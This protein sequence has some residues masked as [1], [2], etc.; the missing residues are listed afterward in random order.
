MMR[1]SLR[2]RKTE[3]E[4]SKPSKKHHTT[5]LPSPAKKNRTPWVVAVIV[6][7][8]TAYLLSQRKSD[9]PYEAS[10]DLPPKDDN[11]IEPEPS[12]SFTWNP[13][14]TKPS[15]AR[16]L[17]GVGESGEVT[18]P[19]A[20]SGSLPLEISGVYPSAD[21][22]KQIY[23]IAG[24]EAI[25]AVY[26][27]AV[28]K[29][30][31]DFGSKIPDELIPFKLSGA[32]NIPGKFRWVT[33]SIFRFDPD[34][35]W[36][37][38]LKFEVV[39]NPDFK[40]FDGASITQA[41]RT[42]KYSTPNQKIRI[43]SVTSELAKDLTDGA[44]F[45][46]ENQEVPPD[47]RIRLS[48]DSDVDIDLISSAFKLS[49]EVS[50]QPPFT[51]ET[52]DKLANR[53]STRCVV[54]VLHAK[55]DLGTTYFLTLPGGTKY[56]ALSGPLT[57]KISVN[58]QGL[59]DFRFDMRLNWGNTIS[60]K[61]FQL[62]L[63]HGLSDENSF[64]DFYEVFSITENNGRSLNYT[65][66]LRDAVI[67]EVNVDI[68]PERIYEFKFSASE[69]IRDGFGLPLRESAATFNSSTPQPIFFTPGE[70]G[71][72]V[73]DPDFSN[74][75]V[76]LTRSYKKDEPGDFE[77]KYWNV[78]EQNLE[79]LLALVVRDHRAKAGFIGELPQAI[80]TRQDTQ[81]ISGLA[82]DMSEALGD[83]GLAIAETTYRQQLG[84]WRV[85]KGKEEDTLHSRY[86]Y[87]MRTNVTATATRLLSNALV[88]WVTD[89]IASEPV[90][91][92]EVLFYTQ[93]SQWSYD[94]SMKLSLL[95]V[96]TTNK[97]GIVIFNMKHNDDI[98]IPVVKYRGQIS[99]LPTTYTFGGVGINNLRATMFTD[100]KI[101][102]PGEALHLK[103]YV[104]L[105]RENPVNLPK[106]CQVEVDWR[107]NAKEKT[108][109]SVNQEFGSFYSKF[110]VPEDASQIWISLICGHS[111]FY[112]DATISDPRLPTGSLLFSSSED[113][114]KP[115]DPRVN[116]H[117][118]TSTYSGS[119]VQ[120]EISV[121]WK[122]SRQPQ[123][124]VHHM[125]RLGRFA[126][127]SSAN[128]E[129]DEKGQFTLRTNSSGVADFEFVLANLTKP[130]TDGNVHMTATWI[131]PTREQ[132]T[133][134]INLQIRPSKIQLQSSLNGES[135]LPG[136]FFVVAADVTATDGS[137]IDGK[138][139]RMQLISVMD[140]K[141][142]EKDANSG[143]ITWD[144]PTVELDECE[145]EISE[146]IAKCS[147]SLPSVGEFVI[148][149]SVL[150]DSGYEVSSILEVGR[151]LEEWKESPLEKFDGVTMK[152]DTSQYLI[153]DAVTLTFKSH[154]EHAHALIIWGNQFK[155]ERKFVS[156]KEGNQDIQIQLG[157]ECLFGGCDLVAIISVPKQNS[158]FSLKSDVPISPLYDPS[159]ARSF[160]LRQHLKVSDGKDARINVQL[161]LSD[162]VTLPGTETSV[163]VSLTDSKGNPIEG[164][165]VLWAVD[166]SILDL[167]QSPLINVTE[168]TAVDFSQGI[169]QSLSSIQNLL[170]EKVYRS[171]LEIME[172]RWNLDPWASEMFGWLFDDQKW[173]AQFITRITEFPAVQRF[174]EY[175]TL[176]EEMA[177][178]AA[179]P[180]H[181]LAKSRSHR[182]VATAA[183]MFS[184]EVATDRGFLAE[185]PEG[186]SIRS[187]FNLVPLFEASLRVNGNATVTFKLPDNISSSI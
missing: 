146:N 122:L 81:N 54:A 143:K 153:G 93:K 74:E 136:D 10:T 141:A 156:I 114:I 25:T 22:L 70:T 135:P 187:N 139:V 150:D 92:A 152:S 50:T 148:V 51:F 73:L 27:R 137:A 142:Y 128:E 167:K 63:W 178:G 82:T 3:N 170:T 100:R 121:V 120:S 95:G 41:P 184:A 33:T 134:N 28:I 165:V 2:E 174:S 61:R 65:L 88:V 1:P 154:F 99:V 90:E 111:V 21:N 6:L 160:T 14:A 124:L 185:S 138:K 59:F 39:F 133:K 56:H 77:V 72:V 32:E 23:L 145:S 47:G 17:N 79:S 84:H 13:F 127:S 89:M 182:E 183:M 36:P 7:S 12:S 155:T 105:H 55:L 179:S 69:N 168:A 8:L 94:A 149:T 118:E 34:I 80:L 157:E 83:S 64:R 58:F 126:G 96:E 103:G 110:Y 113:F 67:L 98:I 5:P 66:I 104:R 87:V 147:F 173:L 132:V 78:N 38:D 102:R 116:L 31:S 108:D 158:D 123:N 164:E 171:K 24:R 130:L 15:T 159:A 46:R 30:G 9:S 19:A 176:G 125:K 44:W 109:V 53:S 40:S 163:T 49:P 75:F 48:F 60:H 151:S 91:N 97:D 186:M 85:I 35:D 169:E 57:E 144:L 20:L 177:Y 101:Y 26:N 45:S 62:A 115:Q 181:M 175:F 112:T 52:C 166:K 86:S 162:K 129:P 11:R 140:K 172:R 43:E 68:S 131:G 106:K 71:N 107:N 37:T 4:N 16:H 29:L 18:D 180:E 42:Y 119:P 161:E 76:A 117:F